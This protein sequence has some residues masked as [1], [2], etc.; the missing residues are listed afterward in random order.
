VIH[1]GKV[2]RAMQ[3]Q[4]AEFILNGMAKLT[5]LGSGARK[6]DR[7]V[8][9]LFQGTWKGKH[10]RWIVFA[11]KSFVQFLRFFIAGDQ[12][13]EFPALKDKAL[14]GFR[15]GFQTPGIEGCRMAAVTYRRV[16]VH[17]ATGW[18]NQATG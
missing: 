8:A 9:A 10:V 11:S 12:A 13:M 18:L 17:Q 2:Q 7:E 6:R 16:G 15:E 5:R 14:N 3:N 1:S 4:N